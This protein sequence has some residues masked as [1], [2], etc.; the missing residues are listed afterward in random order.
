MTGIDGFAWTVNPKSQLKL[1]AA[2]CDAAA[3]PDAPGVGDVLV[4]P[5]VQAATAAA[6][7]DRSA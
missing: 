6:T 1:T 5:G 2:R 3:E 4:P 7:A